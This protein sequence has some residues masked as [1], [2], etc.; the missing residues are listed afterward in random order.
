MENRKQIIENISQGSHNRLREKFI[1]N[2]FKTEY[3]IIISFTS[4][5]DLDFKQRIWHWVNN[6]KEYIK[7]YCGNK[8]SFKNSW[9]NGYKKYC[10]RKCSSN[11]KEVR[12]K[13]KKTLK[14]KY[15]V[16]HYSKTK[17]Y[18][19]K[20]KKTSQERYG[21]DNFSKNK[22]FVL[23]SK[24]TYNDK[25]WIDSYTK[26]KEYIEKSKKTSQE[27]YG[28]DYY[29]QTEEFRNRFK[30]T[31]REKYGVESYLKNIEFRK[32]KFKI[33]NN[34]NY[35]E[36]LNNGNH[37]MKCDYGLK[38]NFEINTDNYFGRIYNNNKLC[39]KCNPI[40]DTSSLKEKE[41]YE[42][43]KSVYNGEVIK[44]YRDK[45]EIDIFI[46][47]FNI[48]FEFNGLYWHSNKFKDNE[49]HLKKTEYFKNKG[50]KIIHIWED[51]WCDKKD[52]IKS[53]IMYS[54]KLINDKIFAR[55][56]IVKEIDVNESSAFLNK[57]HIQGTCNSIIKLGLFY[58]NI[59]VSIMAFDKFE[60]RKN[61]NKNE[62]NLN[63]F[64]NL[65]NTTVIGSASKLLNYFIKKYKPNRIISYADYSWS[66]GD[67]YN[68]L[69]FIKTYISKPDYK[70]L[71]DGNRKHKSNIRKY[72]K[73][74][75]KTESEF[76][77]ENIIL[78]IYDCGKIKYEL[79][80]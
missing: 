23:K 17:E 72:I 33:T 71:I 36:Y 42:Y 54:L 29:N 16:D 15:G 57:N 10:S 11:S 60:G 9:K 27:K 50:I 4:H 38:H 3:D 79:N 73:E 41:L 64:C 25:Y 61:M 52:I 18:T 1:H 31:M 37:L 39:T 46:P 67:L 35:L 63:R 48:G 45:F 22:A 24:K 12:D 80:I 20:V 19:K 78:K 43:I 56:C 44:G 68:V 8:V 7:C 77:K 51:E 69:G 55:K 26:T 59:L 14:E 2:N 30:K 62:W 34:E 76:V 5:L 28:T 32:S 58:N 74:S 21:V 47:D 65:K 70:Y 6:E 49:Y 53:Q 66:N 40:S 13:N 75:K